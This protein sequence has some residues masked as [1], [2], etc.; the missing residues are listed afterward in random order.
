MNQV[1]NLLFASVLFSMLI[2]TGCN[3]LKKMVQMAE[4]QELTV[5]PSPLEVHANEVEFTMSAVLPVKMLKKD[6]VYTVNTFYQYGEERVD[7]EI[8][9]ASCRERVCHRV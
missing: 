1:K 4:D 2:F 6:K 8:G 5:E 3:S 9:R 7:V